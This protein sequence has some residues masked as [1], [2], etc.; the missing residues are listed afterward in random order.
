MQN[1]DGGWAAFDR[2]KDRPI[3]E[4]IPFADHNAM[5]DPS[6]PD[7][8]GRV[9][10]GL[11]HC[12]IQLDHPAVGPAIA[13]IKQTSGCLRRL[14]G[15]LGREFCLWN[16]ADFRW[17]ESHRPG[18]DR[19]YIQKAADWLRS[20]QKPDGS[21]GETALSYRRSLL[22]GARPQHGFANGVGRDGTA[23]RRRAE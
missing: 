12:R 3:L 22:E 19:P 4:K 9:L 14:V 17:T 21:F 11:G 16:L 18:H 6:C 23:R 15:T 5:Q 7:I 20:V 1:D 10:E 2:T 8:T 13:F